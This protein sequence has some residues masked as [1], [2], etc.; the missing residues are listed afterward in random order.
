MTQALVH[1]RLT[2]TEAKRF[3]RRLEKL[4]DEF[5]ARESADGD[6]YGFA[7]GF[8]PVDES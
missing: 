2:E 1:A 3:L 8:Y 4:I 7:L 6:P 5:R